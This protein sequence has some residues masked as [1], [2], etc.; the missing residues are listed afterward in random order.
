MSD[1]VSL[2]RK[3]L[4]WAILTLLILLLP[5]IALEIG[6]RLNGVRV[7]DDPY[8][9]FGPVPSFFVK[10]RINGR[11]YYHVVDRML[12]RERKIVF[13]VQKDRGTFRVF[14][15][16]ASASAGWPHPSQEIYSAYLEE[17]LRRA[18]PDKKIEVINVSAHSYPAYRVRLIAQEVLEFDPNLL[19][20]W[21]G[22]AEVIE[23]RVYS[24]RKRWFDPLV[25][26]AN[27]STLYRI[28]RGNPLARRWFPDNTLPADYVT[29]QKWTMLAQL[30]PEVRKNPEQY[31]RVKR[32]YAHS[33]E[34]M[35]KS[36]QDRG[37]PVILVTVPVNLRDWRPNVSYQA[38]QG[39][40]LARWRKHYTSGRAALLK[41]DPNTAVREL[42]LAASLGPLHGETHF[43]LAQAFEMKG[44]FAEA[45]EQFNRAR[46]LDY[47]PSRTY[48]DFNA[49]LHKVASRYDGVELADAE[50][51]FRSASA[52]RASGFDLFL[53]HVHPT[54]RGNLLVAE[55]VFDTI[56]KGM[57]VDSAPSTE[58]FSHEAKLYRCGQE[59][60]HSVPA[61]G[62]PWGDTLYDDNADFA[63]QVLLVKL[64]T[65]MHQNE[66]VAAKL[67]YLSD[68][69]GV[70][71][72][73]SRYTTFLKDAR[74]VYVKLVELERRE[75]LGESVESEWKDARE[76]LRRFRRKYFK[77]YEKFQRRRAAKK[78][79]GH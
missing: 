47:N 16:G 12:Y 19:I 51:A 39:D 57:F 6:V 17:A 74:A 38:L 36:A 25:D 4:F 53:D 42:G 78:L 41:N 18:Y 43:H 28:L 24:T 63:M 49:V 29:W 50:A 15:L 21:S 79:A 46:D 64:F 40:E 33:I 48:S 2:A 55:T 10:Q 68:A 52:P 72:L 75:L 13:P 30:P 44:Q 22:N 26:I 58:G 69:P 31:E 37:V 73:D 67:S 9:Q 56:V 32:H 54:K 71:T 60:R 3:G 5:L 65:V 76:N 59:E 77:G 1:D 45:S 27:R 14:C 70:D 20:I 11:Q 62:C 35:V 61:S 8:L 23:P 34:S 66:N 7:S